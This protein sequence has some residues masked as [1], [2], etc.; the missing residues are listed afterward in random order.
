MGIVQNEL[1][2]G[3][4]TRYRYP[5]L[6]DCQIYFSMSPIMFNRD[7]F[8]GEV[9]EKF[10]VWYNCNPVIYGYKTGNGHLFLYLTY[11]IGFND[12]GAE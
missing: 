9:G 8:D 6:P 3:I 1:I 7:S 10:Q 12:A 11:N 2:K 5:V 4:N